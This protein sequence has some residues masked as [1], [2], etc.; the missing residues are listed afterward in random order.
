MDCSEATM[1]NKGK[2][3]MSQLIADEKE[4]FG[5]INTR[6]DF[7]KNTKTLSKEVTSY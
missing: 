3:Q 6:D 4:K 2:L 5:K 7:T 1:P